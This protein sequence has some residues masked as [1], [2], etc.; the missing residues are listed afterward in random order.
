MQKIKYLRKVKA[1]EGQT[2]ETLQTGVGQ[3]KSKVHKTGNYNKIPRESWTFETND[4]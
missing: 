4:Q 2:T 3:E 1:R